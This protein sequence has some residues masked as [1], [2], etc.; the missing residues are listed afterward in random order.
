[1]CYH[2]AW[3]SKALHYLMLVAVPALQGT[4]DHSLSKLLGTPNGTARAQLRMLEIP[5]LDVP[6]KKPHWFISR[7][8][9]RARARAQGAQA[10]DFPLP[11]PA[12]PPPW[13]RAGLCIPISVASG[14]LNNTPVVA[15]MIPIV[16]AWSARI[17]VPITQLLV[18]LSFASM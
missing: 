16:K 12:N 3:Q 7:P 15:I 9:C 4:L 17:G 18:P 14:F 13:H 6:L 8:K 10:S 11:S 2:H 1:M 5:P